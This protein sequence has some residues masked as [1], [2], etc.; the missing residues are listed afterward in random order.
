MSELCNTCKAAGR[1]T[2][3]IQEIWDGSEEKFNAALRRI[4]NDWKVRDNDSA[5][6]DAHDK[7][8]DELIS[9]RSKGARSFQENARSRGC[10]CLT[11][12]PFAR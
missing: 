6:K 3:E 8:I 12:L 11:I 2:C 7:A 5:L 9:S 1:T 10:T 4:D